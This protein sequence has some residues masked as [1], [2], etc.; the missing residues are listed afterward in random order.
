M[1]LNSQQLSAVQHIDTPLLVLAGAGSG[2]TGVITEKI[3]YLV[4]NKCYDPRSIIAVTFTNKAAQE[5]RAR[6]G[7]KLP[8]AVI[9]KLSI[10]TFH[11]LGLTMLR[12][13]IAEAGLRKGFTILDQSDAAAAL[14]EIV[15]EQKSVLE[16]RE[17]QQRISHWKNGFIN[18]ETALKQ[19]EDGKDQMMARI[20]AIYDQ[21][22]RA[23]NSVDFDDLIRLPVEVL[24]TH[25]EIHQY[26]QG[27]VRHLLI[28][29]YQDTN[30]AQYALVQ[31]LVDRFGALTAVGDDDQSIYSWRGARPDNLVALKDDYPNL[32][33]VKLEQNYRS[34]QRILRSA[35]AVIA[36]NPHTFEKKLWSDLGIGDELRVSVCRHAPDE[37][38]WVSGQILTRHFQFGTK[39]GD[40]AILYR[41]NFQSRLFEQALR[42]KS[43]SYN[44]TGGKSFFD[45]V[46]IKD[47]L[48]YLR[49]LVNTDDDTAFLRCVNTPRREIGP[50]TLTKLGE[51]ARD[52]SL[53]L[54]DACLHDT[55]ADK[56]KP[57]AFKNLRRFAH[58]ITLTAD[59]A[60]RGDVIKVITGFLDDINYRDWMDNQVET[61]K[62]RERKQLNVDELI[63]WIRRLQSDEDNQERSLED[64]VGRL[65]LHDMLS[66]QEDEQRNDQVQLMTLHAAKGL[67]FPHVFMV[68]MEED[69][70]P[71][72]NSLDD[73]A[74]AEE[75]RLAYV[76]MTRAQHTLTMTRARTRQN[77]GDIN[78]CE[79]SR[80][81]DDLPP[82]DV[83]FLGGGETNNTDERRQIGRDAIANLRAM[84]SAD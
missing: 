58:L 80:F 14:K 32:A 64:I 74:L 48:A 13:H 65:S 40:F 54:F 41:S 55:L 66:H 7:E 73:D 57:R 82:E 11:R 15:H 71:H 4:T 28:D 81:L 52:K 46:E 53:S 43:I 8:K 61:D 60:Q 10:S 39:F 35:N 24:Q 19:A 6:L 33:V 50:N 22:L 49:L 62:Q 5:M 59:N 25:P 44:I 78:A 31:L 36:K 26:W 84:L 3:A 29:E 20:Y 67:E 72:R 68:G 27:R 2:K 69:I 56:L 37:A 42:E 63:G 9:G 83:I 79:P 23:C 75:R 77:H 34:S 70:L 18:H 38:E 45:Q 76:G 51:H 21:W 1:A 16:E 47:L 30:A 12:Q 17:V